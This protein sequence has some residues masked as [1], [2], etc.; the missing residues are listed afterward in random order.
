MSRRGA[1]TIIVFGKPPV[2]GAVKT[3][4]AST[5]GYQGAARLARAMLVDTLQVARQLPR[6]RLQVATVGDIAPHLPAP[7]DRAP[8]Q[9]GPG[10][11]G[12]RMERMLGRALSAPGVD[13]A[14]LVGTDIPGLS[15]GVLAA[16][17]R[18]LEAGHDAALAPTR[19]GGFGVIGLG[20]PPG[21]GLLRGLPWSRPDTCARTL[22]RL[23]AWGVPTACTES[24]L[25]DLDTPADLRRLCAGLRR[26]GAQAGPAVRRALVELGLLPP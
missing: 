9:Q 1:T 23:D 22:E 19:D 3:R 25:A 4:L 24:R 16:L 17:E 7:L 15:V 26:G 5:L 10:D 8:W 21:P 13:R 18:S 6:A 12:Q 20:V 14:L 11:L 2:P